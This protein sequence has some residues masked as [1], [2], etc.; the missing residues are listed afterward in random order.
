MSPDKNSK[1]LGDGW[2][3]KGLK[4]LDEKWIVFRRHSLDLAQHNSNTMFFKMVC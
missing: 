3:G 2:E 4:K 1:E